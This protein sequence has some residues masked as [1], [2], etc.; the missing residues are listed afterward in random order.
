M[1]KAGLAVMTLSL[2]GGAESVN[3]LRDFA[4]AAKRAK[5]TGKVR[6]VAFAVDKSGKAC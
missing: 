5:A 3:W 6:I 1:I 2:F 4:V